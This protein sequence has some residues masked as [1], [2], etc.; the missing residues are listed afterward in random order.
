MRRLNGWL[1]IH[2]WPML[3]FLA[4][5]ILTLP[6]IFITSLLLFGMA[7]T[8]ELSLKRFEERQNPPWPKR[9]SSSWRAF[10]GLEM[11]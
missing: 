9:R 5:V 11:D 4:I 3:H 1:E 7:L 10:A 6:L 2:I 8:L